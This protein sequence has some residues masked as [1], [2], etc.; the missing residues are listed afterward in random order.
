MVDRVANA[1]WEASPGP[2]GVF[3]IN[4]TKDM[5]RAAIAAM[6][7]PSPRMV[8]AGRVAPTDEQRAALGYYSD[9]D[10]RPGTSNC[11]VNAVQPEINSVNT[12]IRYAAMIKAALE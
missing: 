5:A 4:D 12:R 6:T 10:V 1:I 11:D 7:E 3:T 9:P 8:R 2:L